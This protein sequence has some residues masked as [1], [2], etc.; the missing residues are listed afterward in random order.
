MTK[1]ISWRSK[2]MEKYR[3]GTFKID[4]TRLNRGIYRSVIDVDRDIDIITI[5]I[6]TCIPYVDKPM[7]NMVMHSVEHILATELQKDKRLWKIYFGPMGC[8]TGFY[9]V[10][11][12]PHDEELSPRI[13][14]EVLQDACYQDTGVLKVPFNT[15]Q[16]CGNNRTLAK[17]EAD[18]EQV[19]EI[20]DRIS[21]MAEY[22]IKNNEFNEY[23]YL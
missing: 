8:Q 2:T 3:F 15:Q 4:H 1:S 17:D 6:R 5:D 19:V 21:Q 14:G 11:K 12:K 7:S 23:N 20:L 10:I 16:E 22:L 18:I 9:Y 13:L